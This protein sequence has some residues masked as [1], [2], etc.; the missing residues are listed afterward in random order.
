[1][2]GRLSITSTSNDRLKAW[3]ADYT[4][5]TAVVV[6][7]ERYGV[8][9]DWLAA[10]DETVAIPMAGAADSVNVAVAA[11]VV[12]FEAARRRERAPLTPAR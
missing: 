7:G 12:L 5:A 2:P 10:A 4:G 11:G 3:E 1:M 9:S 8:T 6:G